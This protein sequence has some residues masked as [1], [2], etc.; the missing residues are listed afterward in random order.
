MEHTNDQRDGLDTRAVPGTIHLV[1]LEG[2]MR[3]QHA[4]ASQLQD[5]VLVPSPSSDPDDP[6]NWTPKRK[7]LSTACMSMYTLMVGI[8][9]AAVYSVLEPISEDTGLTVDQLNAG[10]G[11]MFL[12]FGW[13][14]LIAQP[15]ALQYGKRPVYLFSML[16]T[17]GTMLWVPYATSNSAWIGSKIL[18]GAVGAP[19]ES[20]CEISITDIYFAHERGSYMGLYAFMLAGSNFLAPILAGFIN[21][22]QGWRWV[23]Y[24][25]AIFLAI[26]FVFCFFLMEETN[27]DRAPLEKTTSGDNT[28]GVATPKEGVLQEKSSA[29]SKPRDP[30]KGTSVDVSRAANQ[31]T[32]LGAVH[33]KPKTY[34]QKLS[35]KD[36]KRDF[37]L[38]RMMIRPL[39]FMSLPSIAY[40]GFSYGSNLIWFN[41]LNGTASLILSAPPYNF[42]SSMVGL[43]YVSPLLGVACASFYS[44][45]IGD[46]VVLWFARRNKGVL[47]AEHRLWLF[48]V[49]IILIPASLILWGVGAAHHIHWFGLIFAM[50]LIAGSN[51]IGLQLSVS[52]CI[53]SYKDLSGEAMATVI[54]IRNTMSFAMGYGI[55][56]WVT[57]MGYQNAFIVAAFAGLAQVLTFF[58]VVKWGK[59]WRNNTKGR[60]YKYV[61]ENEILGVTH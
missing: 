28:P 31:N 1:D 27:Y 47:E 7:M 38:F 5:V 49:S 48:S 14:T 9:S 20:L 59:S 52:Y 43:S 10:T 12:F 34:V 11:Y 25:C 33:Y 55:T 3:G 19:V 23:M 42:S 39:I 57:N 2:V 61:K 15:I 26:G 60:Y 35:L 8:A 45:V 22:G 17:L 41:V 24:W 32:E 13:G 18:Q 50:F 36:K 53:D 29:S 56:P 6:L 51:A 58:A 54:I 46:K 4:S 16:A 37:R 44:G 30:E 40:A 21:D